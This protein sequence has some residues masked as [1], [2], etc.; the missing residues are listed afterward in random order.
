MHKMVESVRLCFMHYASCI[1]PLRVSHVRRNRPDRSRPAR[2]FG[3]KSAGLGGDRFAGPFG[4]LWRIAILCAQGCCGVIE[5]NAEAGHRAVLSDV[6][7]VRGR[8]FRSAVRRPAGSTA[9]SASA[10]RGTEIHPD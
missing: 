10:A 7:R 2:T 6:T 4:H 1:T 5:R 3:E 8:V 9:E